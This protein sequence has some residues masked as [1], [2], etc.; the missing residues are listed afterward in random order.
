MIINLPKKAYLSDNTMTNISES[1]THKM[2]AKTGWHR[3][4][5]KLRH[6]HPV[7]REGKRADT[8]GTVLVSLGW[9]FPLLK[10]KYIFQI[11][12]TVAILCQ[13]ALGN[14]YGLKLPKC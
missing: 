5:S 10:Y 6:C 14:C 13:T 12:Y 11:K 2:A 3:Y 4:E 8:I 1:F 7:Y 9:P